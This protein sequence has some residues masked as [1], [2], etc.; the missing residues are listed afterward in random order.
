[1]D[2]NHSWARFTNPG[3]LA[4][5]CS[6]TLARVCDAAGLDSP[7]QNSNSPNWFLLIPFLGLGVLEAWLFLSAW[8][9]RDPEEEPQPVILPET[10]RSIIL[11]QAPAPRASRTALQRKRSSRERVK[12]Q[13]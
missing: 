1:M 6:G 2:R 8:K 4:V 11:A 10:E 3:F 12:I 9:R 13:V 5:I 7:V